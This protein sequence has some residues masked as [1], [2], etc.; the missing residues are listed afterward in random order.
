MKHVYEIIYPLAEVSVVKV[1]DYG[2]NLNVLS[3]LRSVH[4]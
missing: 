3:L 1:A 2:M 4:L